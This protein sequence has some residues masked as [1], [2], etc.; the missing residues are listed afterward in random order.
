MRAG[1]TRTAVTQPCRPLALSILSRT[2]HTDS[3]LQHWCELLGDATRSP[4]TAH[5]SRDATSNNHIPRWHGIRDDTTVH[6]ILQR[7]RT[8][9]SLLAFHIRQ[10][11][12]GPETTP[13]PHH[14]HFEFAVM[15][16]CTSATNGAFF[17][18]PPR[19]H[20]PGGFPLRPPRCGDAPLNIRCG[21]L[22]PSAPFQTG[23]LWGRYCCSNHQSHPSRL[24]TF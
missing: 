22:R 16:W 11:P 21:L 15:A 1:A 20:P 18:T 12:H 5:T 3:R 24:C 14:L 6:P 9:E 2:A 17:P 8:T 10:S 23:A 4:L 7:T 13:L 19:L